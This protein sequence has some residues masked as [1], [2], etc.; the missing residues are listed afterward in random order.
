VL[1]P[2]DLTVGQALEPATFTISQHEA[3]AY[4]EA[5]GDAS[6]RY[7][8]PDAPLPPMLLAARGLQLLM[9]QVEVPGGTVHG[10]QECEFFQPAYA[11]KE[12]RLTALVPRVAT[13]QGQRFV[14]LEMAIFADDAPVCRGRALLIIPPVEPVALH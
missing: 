13:R 14:T 1:N 5:V 10:G 12:M 9:G 3:R 6:A 8:Q 2:F 7:Q 11:G 4:I